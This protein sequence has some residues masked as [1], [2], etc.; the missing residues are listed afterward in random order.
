MP[1]PGT[2]VILRD[3]TSPRSVPVDT[4]VFF[5]C[6]LSDR[7]LTQAIAVSSLTEFVTKFGA[8]QSYSVLYDV[9]DAFFREGGRKAYISRVVGPAATTGLLTL[10]DRAGTPL[11]TLRADAFGPGA[12]SSGITIQI[13][14]GVATNTFIVTIRESGNV[15]E[16]SPDLATPDA[17]VAWSQTSNYIR[18]VNLNSATA[19]PNNNPA[20]LAATALSAGND[21]RASIVDAQWT[22]ALGKF[23]KGLGPG[24]VAMPGRTTSVA[25]TD[26]VLHA[27]ANSRVALLDTSDTAVV[28]TLQ[29]FATTLR[30]GSLF[31][32]WGAFF[33]PW[34]KIP[35]LTI[36]TTRIVPPSG[37][38]AGLIARNDALG[39]PNQPAAGANG[40]SKFAIG[41]SQVAWDETNR[42]SLN[43]SGI[44]VFRELQGGVRLYGFRSAV[45]QVVEPKWLQFNGV[46][47]VM[48]YLSE[49]DEIAESHVFKQL[50]G[51]GI[52]ISKYGGE[53][54]GL[55]AQYYDKGA[56]FGSTPE[57]AFSVEVGPSVNTTATI[58]NGELHAVVGLKTSPFAERVYVE[59][60]KV[61]VTE[62]V[63]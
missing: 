9:M 60:V 7:G 25:H 29:G 12:W 34:I 39:N 62:A 32:K 21:D 24:Q 53:L 15:V 16:V 6:G 40:V 31:E 59:L 42:G 51:E 20:V 13:A 33:S 2:E 28:A 23:D 46:R 5:A 35:G 47:T 56:L 10:N 49:A 11:P 44:N 63:A 45:D 8:R 37:T 22:A 18:L 36:G 27:S 55:A 30:G 19:A 48:S 1:T 26:L 54:T 58:A 38:V 52:E 57:E 3:S 61:G 41:L 43:S 14:N 50:D 17:A 4:G